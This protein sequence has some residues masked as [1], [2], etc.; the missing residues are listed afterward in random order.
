M[1]L[2]LGWTILLGVALGGCGGVVDE[3]GGGGGSGNPALQPRECEAY[4]P[5]ECVKPSPVYADVEP[6]FQEVCVSCHSG[7]PGAE[8]PLTT[9]RHIADWRDEVRAFLSDCTMPP[10]DSGI[11]LPE[12]DRRLVLD[13]LRCGLPE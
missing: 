8:W 10:P 6:I 4:A 2:R 1:Y 9:H 3:P 11:V 5:V 13:W 12:R 7:E